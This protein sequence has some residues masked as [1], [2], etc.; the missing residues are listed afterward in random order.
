MSGVAT[1]ATL[2]EW[3]ALEAQYETVKA[4]TLR[5]L[6]PTI[7]GAASAVMVLQNPE[8]AHPGAEG[9]GN[10]IRGPGR[11]SAG[12]NDQGLHRNTQSIAGC[13]LRNSWPIS[14]QSH[15]MR[16]PFAV[17]PRAEEGLMRHVRGSLFPAVLS[18]CA[19]AQVLAG[20]GPR[21]RNWSLDVV[22]NCAEANLQTGL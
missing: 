11:S 22:D 13:G 7:W 15:Q 8:S 18:G 9:L 5:A 3:K 14:R 19:G 2:P 1:A 4:L 17:T 12:K 6:S 21:W 10:D 16:L 20:G